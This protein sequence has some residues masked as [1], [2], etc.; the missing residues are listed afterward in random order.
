MNVSVTFCDWCCAEGRLRSAWITDPTNPCHP[1][2]G[3]G[4]NLG[5]CDECRNA[6][7]GLRFTELAARRELNVGVTPVERRARE[8]P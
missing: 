6:L 7:M 1:N 5:L 3:N 4:W 8:L 2:D